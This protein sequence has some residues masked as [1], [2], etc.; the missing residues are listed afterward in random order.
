[1]R[2]T[3][4]EQA[5]RAVRPT[6]IAAAEDDTLARRVLELAAATAPGP[7]WRYALRQ[8]AIVVTSRVSGPSEVDLAAHDADVEIFGPEA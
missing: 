2:Y 8:D 4:T 5:P 1:M 7:G 3:V 6:V